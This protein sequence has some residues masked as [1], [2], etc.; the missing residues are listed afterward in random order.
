MRWRWVK[1][2]WLNNVQ[3]QR[4][5][6]PTL[7]LSKSLGESTCTRER[8][9]DGNIYRL[10]SAFDCR[11]NVAGLNPLGYT[12]NHSF[13]VLSWKV[14]W[15]SGKLHRSPSATKTTTT[16]FSKEK[17]PENFFQGI[18]VPKFIQGF[19]KY[20]FSD[21]SIFLRNQGIQG[22]VDTLS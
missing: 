17:R 12:F 22:M 19:S 21:P 18:P 11:L 5:M 14:L 10:V 4:Y 9:H 15:T 13:W 1:A 7:L 20:A 3:T 8:N 2:R 16:N 6:Q